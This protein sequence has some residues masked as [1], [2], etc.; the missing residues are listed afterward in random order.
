MWH[1]CVGNRG[2][3]VVPS[4]DWVLVGEEMSELHWIGWKESK[5]YPYFYVGSVQLPYIPKTHPQLKV[6]WGLLYVSK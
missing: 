1:I 3:K 4:Y 2:L 6:N 5:V